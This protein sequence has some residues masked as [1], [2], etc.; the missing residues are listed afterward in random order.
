MDYH[1]EILSQSNWQAVI[2]IFNY[3]IIHSFAAY[4]EQPVGYDF[5]DVFLNMAAGYP[6]VTAQDNLGRVI[7][8]AF[9]RSYH[10]APAFRHTAEI[11]YFIHPDHT[12]R[13]LGTKILNHL[14]QEAKKINITII[15]ANISS[16]NEISLNF[17]RQHGFSE[18][19]RFHG[20][21]EKFGQKF[22]VIW[23]QKDI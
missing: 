6:A 20:V 12:R 8:F 14:I 16:L 21:G 18:S 5:F 11:T 4:P 3:Y 9:L 23:M 19:G 17:H 7:G 10:P 2:D 15:L 22:D 13:G 1:L